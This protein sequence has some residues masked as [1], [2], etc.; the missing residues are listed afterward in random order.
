MRCTQRLP[1]PKP[2]C[3]STTFKKRYIERKKKSSV[4]NQT[5]Y[6]MV[7]TWTT[8]EKSHDDCG[9]PSLSGS[10]YEVLVKY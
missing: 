6:L 4:L 10:N 2:W 7:V 9:L 3:H 8:E 5:K 1:G